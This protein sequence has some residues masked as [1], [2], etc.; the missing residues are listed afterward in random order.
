MKGINSN[1]RRIAF[2]AAKHAGI[3][4]KIAARKAMRAATLRAL[5]LE[6]IAEAEAQFN[7]MEAKA[8]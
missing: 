5:R 8:S 4:R 1:R 2:R 6:A 3:T 7:T